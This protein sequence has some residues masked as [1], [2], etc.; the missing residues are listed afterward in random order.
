MRK[1]MEV[2][3]SD[4]AFTGAYQERCARARRMENRIS[5]ERI[6][7]EERSKTCG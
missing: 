2:Y 3:D 7:Y 4:T 1:V 6:G 5:Y